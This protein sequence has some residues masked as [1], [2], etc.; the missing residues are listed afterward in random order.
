MPVEFPD[1][2]KAKWH[3]GHL[4]SNDPPQWGR[5]DRPPPVISFLTPPTLVVAWVGMANFCSDQV[6]GYREPVWRGGVANGGPDQRLWSLRSVFI[7]G[8]H[9]S[10]LCRLGGYA[11]YNKTTTHDSGPPHGCSEKARPTCGHR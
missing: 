4:V 5:T 7:I 8:S 6:D 2:T 9:F 1:F 11:S 10:A 3:S